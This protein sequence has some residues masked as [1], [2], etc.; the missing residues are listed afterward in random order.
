MF[1]NNA[2]KNDVKGLPKGAQIML[3]YA[4]N[5]SKGAL[6]RGADSS[7]QNGRKSDPRRTLS[8][9]LSPL[10]EHSFHSSILTQKGVQKGTKKLSKWRPEATEQHFVGH[11]LKV[12]EFCLL[13]HRFWHPKRG[14]N[15]VQTPYLFEV[16]G[17]PGPVWAH[18]AF[19]VDFGS[20]KGM[21]RAFF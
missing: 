6:K 16:L 20:Q 17:I 13:F 11:P 7:V 15:G 2:S 18:W 5:A 19:K 4:R 9:E 3:K 1:E 14:Q 12:S 21:P 8:D 10:R